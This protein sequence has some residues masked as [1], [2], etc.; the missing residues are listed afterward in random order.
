MLVLIGLGL[1]FKDIS[2]RAQ[3][4]LHGADR[5]LMES[6]TSTLSEEYTAYLTKLTNKEIIQLGKAGP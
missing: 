1:D 2:V 5:I 4:F 3:E 6:Y